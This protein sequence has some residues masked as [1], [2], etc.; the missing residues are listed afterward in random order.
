[1]RI[2]VQTQGFELTSAID[3]YLRKKLMRNLAGSERDIV[4]I[5]VFLEDIN[6]APQS[7]AFCK[8]HTAQAQAYSES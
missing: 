5:D 4:A 3:R 7:K 1:M 6:G 8:G 2:Y